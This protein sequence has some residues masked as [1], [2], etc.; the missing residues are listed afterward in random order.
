MIQYTNAGEP[1][2]LIGGNGGSLGQSGANGSGD[3][4]GSNGGTA[5]K[6]VDLNGNI[7]TQTVSGDIFGAIS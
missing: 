5:G 7:L 3:G 1:F 6:A 2:N 4:T